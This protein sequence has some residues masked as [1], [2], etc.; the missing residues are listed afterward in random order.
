MGMYFHLSMNIE[1]G[2]DTPKA[3]IEIFDK[4]MNGMKLT[5]KEKGIFPLGIDLEHFFNPKIDFARGG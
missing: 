2:Y 4:K 5:E 1:L 3:V